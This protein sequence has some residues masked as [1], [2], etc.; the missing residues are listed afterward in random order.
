MSSIGALALRPDSSGDN[1]SKTAN[2]GAY[3]R[4]IDKPS[5]DSMFLTGSNGHVVFSEEMLGT[6]EEIAAEAKNTRW[7]AKEMSRYSVPDVRSL[8]VKKA[9]EFLTNKVDRALWFQHVMRLYPALT[10]PLTPA[11]Q[12]RIADAYIGSVAVAEDAEAVG[13]RMDPVVADLWENL[14]IDLPLWWRFHESLLGTTTGYGVSNDV[15]FSVQ[16]CG[17]RVIKIALNNFTKASWANNL[18]NHPYTMDVIHCRQVHECGA[19]WPAG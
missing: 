6:K 5:S 4:G 14:H 12:A 9:S 8:Q 15:A 2:L 13:Q 17:E 18:Y 10:T 11:V 19:M 16:V 3:G 1:I 7:Y